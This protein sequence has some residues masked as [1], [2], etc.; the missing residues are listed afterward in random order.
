MANTIS[1]QFLG[2]V[3]N[4]RKSVSQVNTQIGSL[5]KSLKG[6]A[7]LM[8]GVFAGA[9]VAKGLSSIKNLFNESIKGASD[10]QQS[11]GSVESVFGKQANGIKTVAKGA[12]QAFGLSQ[13]SYQELATVLGAGFKN[14]GIKD[15]AGSAQQTIALGADLAAQYGGSTK[16]AVEAIG[17]LMRG[18]A[19]PIEKYGVS[20]KESAISAELAATGQ[21]NLK[22]AALEQAKAQARLKLLFDQ[23]T[24]AQGAFNREGQTYAV[25]QQKNAA[26]TEN[27][28]AKLG[29]IFLPMMT[30]VQ[31]VIANQVLPAVER[32]IP[33]LAEFGAKISAFTKTAGFAAI[34][35]KVKSALS[36]IG[37]VLGVVVP[38]IGKFIGWLVNN[39]AGVSAF[40]VSLG[41]LVG[42][43][44]ALQAVQA[45]LAAG[46]IVKFITTVIKSTRLWA[47]AQA[48]LNVALSANPI[49]II[50][51]AIAALVAG[52]IYAYKH[53]E[54][55][56]AIVTAAWNGIKAVAVAVFNFVKNII[57]GAFNAYVNSAQAAGQKMRAVVTA[58]WN[59]IKALASSIWNGVKNVISTVWNA[60]KSTVSNA[61]NSVRST[62]TSRMAS[63]KSAMTNAWN[64]VKHATSAVWS[65]IKSA[66]SN[67]I[68]SVRSAVSSRM[69]AIKSTISS[70]WNSVKSLTSSAWN[71]IRS[72]VTNAINSVR[73][74]V[75]SR[76]SAIRST[77]SS[78][79]SAVRSATS[80]AWNAIKSVVSNAISNLISK[81]RSISGSVRSALS[82]AGSLLVSAGRQLIQGLINGVGS[83]A[84]ALIDKAKGIVSDAVAGAKNLL[85]IHSPSKVFAEIGK[86]IGLGLVVGLDKSERKVIK[87]FSDLSAGV[88][89]AFDAELVVSSRGATFDSIDSRLN[90]S[91]NGNGLVQGGGDTYNIEVKVPA[92]ADP[93]QTGKEIVKAIKAYSGAGG[94]VRV[95]TT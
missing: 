58:A 1:V 91:L 93:V 82:N 36:T 32:L 22:G 48:I 4:I 51:I 89:K 84:G 16:D 59:G 83:M 81:V 10:L 75:S 86:N 2:D 87:G 47:A 77:I 11:T 42:S 46:G 62:V 24:S 40:A 26:V 74:A 60:I 64:A 21:N 65:A 50:I 71:A 68:N 67:A 61:I 27:L 88:T 23:T 9:L 69:S 49:G 78:G 29:T 8:K 17:S 14:Q 56:R 95:V 43:Y 94:N 31:Q 34:M 20:I 18:E 37:T 92:T 41:V 35:E 44:K 52:I 55:F 30:K 45:V 76:I 66:V 63:V 38:L 39:Q 54:K 79:W 7:N 72:A 80:S 5:G 15:F 33:K 28:K 12:A 57:V 13:N 70:A 25:I 3:S 53:S 6:A 73:S 85:G 19:D 90:A